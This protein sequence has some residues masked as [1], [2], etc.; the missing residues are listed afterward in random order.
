MYTI[1]IEQFI[2]GVWVK[3]IELNA[4]SKEQAQEK[5]NEI[6]NRTLAAP[7]AIFGQEGPEENIT[8][9][10]VVNAMAGPIRVLVAPN[11]HFYDD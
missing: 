6:R 11:E 3:V 1:L 7:Y 8:R 2:S 4:N 5:K 9:F 10:A